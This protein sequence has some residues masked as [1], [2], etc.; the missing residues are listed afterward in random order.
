MVFEYVTG[1]IMQRVA[2]FADQPVNYTTILVS[3]RNISLNKHI[4]FILVVE[5]LNEA[6]EDRNQVPKIPK[7]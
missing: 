5:N 7:S 4:S 2:A 3:L 1:A 6:K